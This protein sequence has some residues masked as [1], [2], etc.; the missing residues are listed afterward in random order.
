MKK[1]LI[2]FSSLAILQVVMK[3]KTVFLRQFIC[4]III[5]T[6]FSIFGQRSQG[7]PKL[8][9]E[10]P[11]TPTMW[12]FEKYGTYPVGKHT[13]IPNI[14]IP[15]TGAKSGKISAPISLTYHASGIK[16][17][18][19]ATWVG[20]GWS[21]R[22][23]G[24]ITR[25]V[26]GGF[27][28]RGYKSNEMSGYIEAPYQAQGTIDK[29]T[30]YHQLQATMLGFV[31]TEPDI[32]N[33]SF[34]GYSGSFMFNKST[35]RN[36]ATIA[37]IP[38][39]D[40]EVIPS[41]G[42]NQNM[43]FTII[44]PEGITAQF[45]AGENVSLYRNNSMTAGEG[46]SHNG[47]SAWRLTKLTDYSG[48]DE[49]IFKYKATSHDEFINFRQS[50][51]SV[52]VNYDYCGKFT[53]IS[54]FTRNDLTR[55]T[56]FKKLDSIIFK[57]GFIKF[58]SSANNRID[59]PT[60][61]DL[62]LDNIETYSLLN[63]IPK[64]IEKHTFEY[65]YFKASPGFGSGEPSLD[66][67][68]KLT[69]I[70]RLNEYNIQDKPYEFIYFMD[71]GKFPARFL[72]SQDYWGYFNGKLNYSLIP[73]YKYTAIQGNQF[74]IGHA[75]RSVDHGYSKMGVIKRIYY[76]TKGYTDF[77]F[78]G[79][80]ATITSGNTSEQHDVGGL[81]IQ[82]IIN[83]DTNGIVK[84]QKEYKYFRKNNSNLSSGV[85]N[86]ANYIKPRDF[87]SARD[88]FFVIPSHVNVCTG[89]YPDAPPPPYW[90]YDL[91]FTKSH[92]INSSPSM[93]NNLATV[94]YSDVK[95]YF[96]NASDNTGYKW[97]FYATRKDNLFQGTGPLAVFVDNSWDRGQ[98][99]QE[100]T[101][102]KGEVDP[103]K[104]VTNIYEKVTIQDP[105]LAFKVGTRFSVPYPSFLPPGADTADSGFFRENLFFTTYYNMP[106]IWKRL[107]S[108][109]T[110]DNG[111][112]SE[113]NFN[114][115]LYNEHSNVIG[116]STS[117]SKEEEIKT[118]FSYAHE[119]NN[120]RL[121]DE[122][123][124]S[125][126]INTK[127]YNGSTKLS[128]Q[129]NIYTTS[130]GNYLPQKIQSAKGS[131]PLEDR[132]IYH[133]YDNNGNP[134]EVSKKDGTKIYYVWGYNQTQPIAKIEGYTATDLANTN[135][136]INTAVMASNS[137]NDRCL[138][139][140]I[141]D[142]K[143]LRNTL[144]TLR[145]SLPNAQVTTFTYD[146]LIGVTSITDPRGETIYYSYDFFNRLQFV[147]DKDGN[148][149]SK[150]EYN[151]KN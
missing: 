19:K 9:N 111:I 115:N 48:K 92:S 38:H 56:N 147:K 18:Q 46:Y 83:Y 98:L 51:A 93:P 149:L 125:E 130:N 142:E 89:G 41:F 23:G 72:F 119:A 145:N 36:E 62:R 73:K 52:S 21:L 67:R 77:D 110:V 136:L 13:G 132:I 135:S 91:V 33:Y 128:E 35:D 61:N 85:Y 88:F 15:I 6:T 86:T 107:K 144:N 58:N 57:N 79:N 34:L 53:Q 47:T 122:N 16:V 100:E 102:K 10:T 138:D 114:Y 69:K 63:N 134:I 101:Y 59:D 12:E 137:D 60:N 30:E 8:I 25:T 31:D 75:D 74:D 95:E 116:S 108:T 7:D 68:L 50:M 76:P 29:S 124:F 120:V 104:T 66:F 151:Y 150:N 71:D 112:V 49:I 133:N 54:E 37:L 139:S 123:R 146:P 148:I 84:S 129:N 96:G 43:S 3:Q 80:T 106:V 99:L 27:D 127:I 118:E 45:E 131:Q 78:E 65:D 64:L 42:A 44:T 22:A 32:F 40:L 143:E 121:I 90:S 105:H 2:P 81:R 28:E 140:E 70:N 109:T 141:C 113:N 1:V 4:L 117:S 87:F 126:L 94:F 82:K 20:L 17:D 55:Y 39:N 103:I 14:S 97:S 26:V 11:T 24:A 5:F